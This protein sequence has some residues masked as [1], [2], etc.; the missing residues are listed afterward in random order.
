M[1][2]CLVPW[3]LNFFPSQTLNCSL[4]LDVLIKI[5][6]IKTIFKRKHI[7]LRDFKF[8]SIFESLFILDLLDSRRRHKIAHAKVFVEFL[9]KKPS[10]RMTNYTH[11]SATSYQKI[12]LRFRF[13]TVEIDS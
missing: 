4:L 3:Q 9:I 5:L 1:T 2:L 7:L 10:E 13:F 6:L 11:E 8:S 12:F